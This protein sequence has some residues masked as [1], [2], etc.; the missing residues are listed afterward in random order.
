MYRFR[1]EPFKVILIPKEGKSITLETV[2]GTGIFMSA[3]LDQVTERFKE[4][5]APH[6]ALG[7]EYHKIK[8]KGLEM[9]SQEDKQLLEEYVQSSN[10][11][12]K[13]YIEY[14]SKALKDWDLGKAAILDKIPKHQLNDFVEHLVAAVLGGRTPDPVTSNL[15]PEELVKK[16]KN[17]N[18]KKK[19]KKRFGSSPM[20]GFAGGVSTQLKSKPGTNSGETGNGKPMNT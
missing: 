1:V 2:D 9:L 6:D 4:N 16:N 8:N 11:I 12:A 14:C 15:T 18:W 5:M 3:V 20:N 7:L 13:F 17:Q 10:R 19:K